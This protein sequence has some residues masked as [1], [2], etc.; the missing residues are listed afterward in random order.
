M[1]CQ[2][3]AMA[4]GLRLLDSNLEAARRAVAMI[5]TAR[6]EISAAYYIVGDDRVGA[7]YLSLLRE[8]AQRGVRV[9][10]LIDG[11]HNDVPVEAQRLLARDGVEIRLY[12][13]VRYSQP[14]WLNRRLHDKLLVADRGRLIV[15]SRNLDEQHFGLSGP[16][17]VDCDAY[18]WGGAAEQASRYFDGLWSG[19][20]VAPCDMD[21]GPFSFVLNGD[22]SDERGEK[23]FARGAGLEIGGQP[24][25]VPDPDGATTATIPTSGVRFLCDGEGVKNR[26][27]GTSA[28]ILALLAQAKVSIDLEAPY[29]ILSGAMKEVLAE[30]RSRGVQVRIVTNSLASTNQPVVYAAYQNQ[31]RYLLAQG[32]EL[33]EYAGPAHY[34]PKT[35]LIDGS[36]VIIGSYNFDP[37]SETLNTEIAIVVNDFRVAESLRV[38]LQAHLKGSNQIG[39]D[40]RPGEGGRHPDAS[41]SR[42]LL[43]PGLRLFAPLLRRAL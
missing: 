5:Q 16:G 43:A 3:V 40:L 37:R 13:P 28:S 2:S 42:I 36:T 35:A 19:P 15:G 41:A 7:M 38:L 25:N 4:D 11:L 22:S 6:E 17:R 12:H 24:L 30:V 20:E 8:A 39:G 9:R 29:F 18:V 10:L 14:T 23:W 33:W 34:H 27:D 31:K 26:S 21:G 32:I 1:A